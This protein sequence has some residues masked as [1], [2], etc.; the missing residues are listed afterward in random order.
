MIV[1]L[2]GLFSACQAKEQPESPKVPSQPEQGGEEL[3]LPPQKEQAG[4]VDSNLMLNRLKENLEQPLSVQLRIHDDPSLKIETNKDLLQEVA[5]FLCQNFTVLRYTATVDLSNSIYMEIVGA[6]ET[7]QVYVTQWTDVED[8][9]HTFV[10]IEEGPLMG[11]YLYDQTTY[12]AL[13]ELLEGWE[14]DNVIT[15]EGT[16]QPLSST[17]TLEQ[18]KKDSS[19]LNCF[20]QYGDS[21]LIGLNQENGGTIFEVVDSSSGKSIQ[22]IQTK[23]RALDVRG[24]TLD[25]YD[26]YILTEDSVHYRSC[27]DPDLKLDFTLPQS[28]KEQKMDEMQQPLFDVD[29]I[30]DELVYIS[31]AGVVLSNQS[32]KRNDLLLRHDRLISLLNLNSEEKTETQ[33]LDETPELT[34]WY[35]APQLM[36]DGKLIVCPIV[37]RGEKDQWAGFSIFNL[38]NGTYKDY[39]DEFD[40]IS[41]FTYPDET[42]LLVLGKNCYD[43][44]NVIS[45]EI[46]HQEWNTANNEQS[47]LSSD[48]HLLIWRKGLN[49]NHQLV[50]CSMEGE[51]QV[52]LHSSGDRF[53]LYGT[54]ESWALF[55]WEDAKGSQLAFLPLDA[56]V[57][58]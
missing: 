52:L 1:L 6:K 39:I 47:L 2:L 50:L 18:L 24:T 20:R 23:S 46:I 27:Q 49:Y 53:V 25:G 15:L 21:L 58:S 51:E 14:Y 36:N 32:G 13:L 43:K 45:R 16:Y 54:A 11:Q 17:E 9:T 28:V 3:P 30:Q 38:M 57:E 4:L 8:G 19:A 40:E 55:G 29:Y 12:P 42:S 31:D 7:Q 22:T 10:Q 41:G 26:F 35:T 34:A 56:T 48:H 37:V 33:A 5:G 44:M